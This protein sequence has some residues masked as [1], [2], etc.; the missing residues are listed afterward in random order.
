[1]AGL[2][3]LPIEIIAT[4]LAD[5]GN[6]SHHLAILCLVSHGYNHFFSPFLYQS[7]TVR[8]AEHTNRLLQLFNHR[9][10]K[11]VWVQQ[12]EFRGNAPAIGT[13]M[14]VNDAGIVNA[15]PNLE[16]LI[17]DGWRSRQG[18]WRS[19]QS[20]TIEH[21]PGRGLEMLQDLW[22]T[23]LARHEKIWPNAILSLPCLKRLSF[24]MCRLGSEREPATIATDIPLPPLE[25]LSLSNFDV[26]IKTI[27]ALVRKRAF[28][29][30]R[31]E[32]ALRV[33]YADPK[34]YPGSPG[35]LLEILRASNP[36]FPSETKTLVHTDTKD[37][38]CS[39]MSF[40]DFEALTYLEVGV[41]N[42]WGA[43]VEVP[44]FDSKTRVTFLQEL[45]PR[46][47]QILSLDIPN[48]GQYWQSFLGFLGILTTKK[49]TIAPRL[50]TV[51]YHRRAASYIL[52]DVPDEHKAACNAA[53][54]EVMAAP[55]SK[56]YLDSRGVVVAA[57][58]RMNARHGE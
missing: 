38:G 1:M 51:V 17:V 16:S 7:V 2:D 18:I 47:L 35:D 55:F 19:I 26:D 11:A 31:F 48:R 52:E 34:E 56:V 14:L 37:W 12:L 49:P 46:S 13:K 5:L 10:E 36:S 41:N 22:I 29:S 43:L 32:E 42:L 6:R 23:G 33:K 53:G 3:G 20:L 30:I 45:F 25:Y 9:P 54:I 39:R 40:K 44:A 21:G 58:D 4:I 24:H 57:K 8:S 27:T 50:H 15:L 28:I